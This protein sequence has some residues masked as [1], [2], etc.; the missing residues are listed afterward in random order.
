MQTLI[1]YIDP[2]TG[3]IVFQVIIAGV[4]GA[5]VT[6]KSYFGSIKGWIK[7]LFKK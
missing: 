6:L 2:G 3:S 1:L 7:G 5:V 4:L